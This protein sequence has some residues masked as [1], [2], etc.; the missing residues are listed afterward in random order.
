MKHVFASQE[1]RLNFL[2][3]RV[4][5]AGLPRHTVDALL[6][7]D[8]RT[9][10]GILAHSSKE[11]KDISRLSD[12]ELK[13][14]E[15]SLDAKAQESAKEQQEFA[16][17]PVPEWDEPIDSK[18]LVLDEE[19][20]IVGTLSDYFGIDKEMVLSHTRKQ[21]AVRI[22][23]LI[24]YLLR[25]YGGMS[26]P[27]IGHLIGGRDHTTIIHSY[28]KTRANIEKNPALKAELGSLPDK[29]TEIKERKLRLAEDLLQNIHTLVKVERLR[30]VP[31]FREVPERNLKA[32]ELY[33]EGLTLKDISEVIG[34][35][36]ERV[37]Q[38]V[39]GTIRQMAI[40][41]S[42][43][44]GVAM[45]SDVLV[46]EESKKRKRVQEA[47]SPKKPRKVPGEKRWSKFYASCK[48]CGT[49]AIP[50]VRRGLCEKCVGQYRST[51]REEIIARQSL[52]G[53][54][55]M[56]RT[57]AVAQ[58]G[59]DF[60]ITKDQ[61]VFCR[62]C[63]L[64]TTG[65]QL[66]GY[67]N[68][69]WSRF[70]PACVTC[71]TT[72]VKHA[73]KGLCENCAG[74]ITNAGRERAIAEHGGVCDHCNIDRETARKRYSRDFYVTK[75][76]KVVCRKCFQGHAR[77]GLEAKRIKARAPEKAGR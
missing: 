36:R 11:L 72:T 29:V 32:L 41:E 71:G 34:V 20:D 3:I 47:K 62:G 68:Y 59:R 6:K 35:S 76:G 46:E 23:D 49:V 1:E 77:W 38:I 8:I 42:I 53:S 63:F 25:E 56:E 2:K 64:K 15:Q 26:Y 44:K 12:N 55:G 13:T 50:H 5:Y 16:N 30:R 4:E 45:D 37:R 74:A 65:K 14:L 9:V 19:E 18:H 54:C 61:R 21:E 40:N 10:G 52:C 58:Y 57:E 70:H 60:Y 24:V 43:T 69:E 66:G 22:R 39:I 51:R 73:K 31:V 33:R 17:N 75:V 28:K 48:V 27:A 7:A 67:K